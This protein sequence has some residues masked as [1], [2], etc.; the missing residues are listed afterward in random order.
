MVKLLLYW[1]KRCPL[2]LDCYRN[3]KNS[4]TEKNF[5]L[6][7]IEEL[8]QKNFKIPPRI[9]VT[10]TLIV[11]DDDGGYYIYEGRNVVKEL[12]KQIKSLVYLSQYNSL[13][14]KR[15]EDSKKKSTSENGESQQVV[16]PRRDVT[17]SNEE[18]ESTVL[19]QLSRD[20]YEHNRNNFQAPA[21]GDKCVHA[22]FHPSTKSLGN[23]VK[24]T[25]FRK[26]VDA[27]SLGIQTTETGAVVQGAKDDSLIVRDVGK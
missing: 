5:N 4:G 24:T 1:S 15:E 20:S 27:H 18:I 25:D 12:E 10:P 19:Q 2:S 23:H 21:D 11:I 22:I 26:K 16:N 14:S 9:T 13:L 17:P 8:V 6:L 3:I 7:Q